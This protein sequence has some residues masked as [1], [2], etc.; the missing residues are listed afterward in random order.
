MCKA[1]VS[2]FIGP[3]VGGAHGGEC[4]KDTYSV[5][6]LVFCRATWL[7]DVVR[8]KSGL[9]SCAL[10]YSCNWWGLLGSASIRT[11]AFTCSIG[12]LGIGELLVLRFSIAT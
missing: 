12:G 11:A 4:A 9:I 5:H 10:S 8:V 3:G 6:V 7:R 2:V 1:D